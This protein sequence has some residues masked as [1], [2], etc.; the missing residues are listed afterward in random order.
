MLTT[1]L[2]PIPLVAPP[3]TEPH[4]Q[5]TTVVYVSPKGDDRESGSTLG[6]PVRTL[7]R[8]LQVTKGNP[9]LKT[10]IILA[11]GDYPVTE[12][13]EVKRDHGPITF[14]GNGKAQVIGGR[15]VK[16]WKPVTASAILNRLSPEARKSV[17]VVSLATA[18]LTPGTLRSRGFHDG[19][20]ISALELFADGEPMTLSRWPN[21]GS[22]TETVES[23]GPKSFRYDGDRPKRWTG[24][25]DP[26][27]FGY[28]RFDWCDTYERVSDLD[29]EKRTVTLAREPDY[30]IDAKRRFYFFNILEELD[31]PGEYFVDRRAGKLY[32]WPPKGTRDT[33]ASEVEGPLFHI[34]NAEDVTLS[35]LTLEGGRDGAVLVDGGK[36]VRVESCTIRNMGTYGVA[37]H[38]ATESGVAHC[39]LTGLGSRGI[40]LFGGNR[41]TLTPASLYA[42]DNHIWAYSRWPRTYQAGVA[43]EGVG[44]RVANNLIEE[45]P[46]N[47]ILLSGNDHLV[48]LNDIR[49]VCLETGDSGAIYM[50]HNLTMRG[51]RIR[52]NR[53]REIVPKLTTAG[54]FTNVMSVYLDDQ[55]SGTE[56]SG[57]VFEGPGTGILIGGGRDNRVE[58]NVFV[59]K[60]PAFHIDERGKDWAKDK[61][62]GF[63]EEA[64][65]LKV[66][67]PPYSS[68]YP[69]L[70]T[71]FNEEIMKA[72]GNTFVRNII[73]G[74]RPFWFQNGL[75][76]RDLEYKDNVITAKSSLSE[77]LEKAPK[78]FQPIPLKQ[79][80]LTTKRPLAG[81]AKP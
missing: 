14:V 30:G 78:G 55:W 51:N 45:A 57:N 37:I 47:A 68:R 43:V 16:G 60:D 5:K 12:S 2:A 58:N 40:E 81:G 52:S 50:G 61:E 21:R 26:W 17:Q 80:G 13:L 65:R 64:R 49:R 62:N 3:R 6:R 77:A 72:T 54:A 11:P 22:Y 25:N 1:L 4:F 42:I 24:P 31:S 10:Q 34:S 9:S 74:D 27:V 36:N 18:G 8:A 29:K 32:F 71:F 20:A 39:D 41:E 66:D 67:S 79:I 23:L 59:G 7:A 69:R 76:E 35:G 63:I 70:A 48:E 73:A 53:F 46:H 15:S 56:I 75:T 28:L 44:A 19:K 38:G 33:V